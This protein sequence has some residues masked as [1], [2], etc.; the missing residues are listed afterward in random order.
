MKQLMVC[1][2]AVVGFMAALMMPMSARAQGSTLTAKQAQ[3][4]RAWLAKGK[5]QQAWALLGEGVWCEDALVEGW[6]EPKQLA[7]FAD[8][9]AHAR[10][11]GK[12]DQAARCT[13]E[14][15]AREG[16][17]H[18][19]AALYETSRLAHVMGE[20]RLMKLMTQASWYDDVKQVR[21]CPEDASSIDPRVSV[22]CALK[23][24]AASPAA[25]KLARDHLVRSAALFA[26][27]REYLRALPR[28]QRARFISFQ[29]K[30]HRAVDVSDE[31]QLW[32]EL[33]KKVYGPDIKAPECASLSARGVTAGDD[34]IMCRHFEKI[35]KRPAPPQ[36]ITLEV[37][38]AG[39]NAFGGVCESSANVYLV[40]YQKR[41]NSV[42]YVPLPSLGY[43]NG[44]GSGLE[45]TEVK[46]IKLKDEPKSALVRVS[47]SARHSAFEHSEYE[48]FVL[49]QQDQA[50]AMSCLS[51]SWRVDVTL[52]PEE[53]RRSSSN[54]PQFTLK[55][56]RLKRSKV[57]AHDFY[58]A[59]YDALEGMTVAEAVEALPKIE[60]KLRSRYIDL[61][62]DDA[63]K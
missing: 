20:A 23:L 55:A 44:C 28:E 5:T 43:T 34:E 24:A 9:G 61:V 42:R 60:A 17:L 29:L 32:A 40:P 63:A 54:S 33:R 50:G 47:G 4:L 22:F 18:R 51:S 30:G 56:G 36:G 13:L 38:E 3:Q 10:H 12:L 39:V 57:S 59:E 25:P 7:L 41:A 35:F 16:S 53:R 48:G 37:F 14:S 11:A 19:A 62:E 27:R 1:A 6:S 46:P 2:L 31:A 8:L 52:D 26:P 58:F 21:Y 45:Q 49:C 15:L